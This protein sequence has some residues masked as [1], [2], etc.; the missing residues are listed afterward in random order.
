MLPQTAVALDLELVLI[1][2]ALDPNNDS[3][4]LRNISNIKRISRW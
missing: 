2:H 1:R 3:N 4:L